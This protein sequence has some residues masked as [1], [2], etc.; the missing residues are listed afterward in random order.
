MSGFAGKDNVIGFTVDFAAY[1]ILLRDIKS[2]FI[3]KIDIFSL[4]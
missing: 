4:G 2:K 1:E 3:K